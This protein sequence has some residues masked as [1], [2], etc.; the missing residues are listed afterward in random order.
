MYW[1]EGVR[2]NHRIRNIAVQLSTVPYPKY[3]SWQLNRSKTGPTYSTPRE[4]ADVNARP[5]AIRLPHRLEL[6]V[7]ASLLL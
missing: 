7:V 6:A 3:S 1:L 2:E 4:A 5:G